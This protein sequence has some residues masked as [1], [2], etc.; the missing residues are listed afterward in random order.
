MNDNDLKRIWNSAIPSPSG[1]GETLALRINRVARRIRRRNILNLIAF[2]IIVAV[3]SVFLAGFHFQRP[4]TYKGI[5]LAGIAMLFILILKWYRQAGL[6][7]YDM[8]TP[9]FSF[10]RTVRNR[11]RFSGWLIRYGVV[12]YMVLFAAGFTLIVPEMF[13]GAGGGKLILALVLGYAYLAIMAVQ[14][15]IRARREYDRDVQPA[16]QHIESMLGQFAERS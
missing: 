7:A 2:V 16:L 4:M 10:L 6:S 1:D 8:N 13:A 14:G 11:L 12:I 3:M 15:I 5:A 9:N